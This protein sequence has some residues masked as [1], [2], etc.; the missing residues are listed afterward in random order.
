MS[1]GPQIELLEGTTKPGTPD[2]NYHALYIHTDD[3]A[4]YKPDTGQES[5]LAGAIF[6]QTADVTVANTVTETTLIGTGQGSA[7]LAANALVVGRTIRVTMRGHLSDTGTPTLNLIVKL[8][9]TEVV[10][11]GAVTLNSSVTTIAFTLVADIVCRTVGGS[12][13]VV[14]NGVL[15]YDDGTTHDLVKV[16]ATTIDTTSALAVNITATWGTASASNTITAQIATIEY[17]M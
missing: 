6:A 13:T 9:A 17:L 10:S 16:A 1:I 7:T 4:Y 3:R 12:G 2:P 8:G 11:T 5:I 15:I 14:A